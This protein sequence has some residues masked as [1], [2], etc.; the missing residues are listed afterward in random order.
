MWVPVGFIV[1]QQ[2]LLL[3]V[4]TR[5]NGES[6]SILCRHALQR[7]A[8]TGRQNFQMGSFIYL[9]IYSTMQIY[10]LNKY[11]LLRYMIITLSLE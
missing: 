9:L 8:Y 7:C 4:H 1:V 11:K 6:V 5:H 3:G 10:F 2:H